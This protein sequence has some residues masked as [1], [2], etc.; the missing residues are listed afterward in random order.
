MLLYI[1]DLSIHYTQGETK[2]PLQQITLIA[3]LALAAGLWS[4]TAVTATVRP[5]PAK[6]LDAEIMVLNDQAWMGITFA[7]WGGPVHFSGSHQGRGY[8]EMTGYD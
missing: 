6:G 2:T 3:G 7:Y 4:A 5:L 8:L 1:R